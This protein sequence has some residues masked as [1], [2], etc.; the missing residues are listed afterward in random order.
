MLMFFVAIIA[1]LTNIRPRLHGLVN[2]SIQISVFAFYRLPLP[3][4]AKTVN[5]QIMIASGQLSAWTIVFRSKARYRLDTSYTLD[6]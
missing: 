1:L 2:S 3:D 5:L 4:L 6:W